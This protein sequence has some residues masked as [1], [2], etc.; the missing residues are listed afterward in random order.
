MAGCLVG[1]GGSGEGRRPKVGPRRWRVALTAGWSTLPIV[2]GG[3]YYIVA[4]VD[5]TWTTP[6]FPDGS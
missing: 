3:A 4:N 6:L 1:L 2:N 5:V